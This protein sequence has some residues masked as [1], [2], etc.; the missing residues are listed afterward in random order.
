MQLSAARSSQ[1]NSHF[2][3]VRFG[4]TLA[5][6]SMG[7]SWSPIYLETLWPRKSAKAVLWDRKGRENFIMAKVGLFVQLL[8]VRPETT[9]IYQISGSANF[10][11]ANSSIH[12]NSSL[13]TSQH[14]FCMCDNLFHSFHN[15]HKLFT[16]HNKLFLLL[17]RK[18]ANWMIDWA[19]L[20]VVLTALLAVTANFII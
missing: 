4:S 8:F 19:D 3:S 15:C 17:C 1:V 7:E 18:T 16:I 6:V 9:R 14:K 12:V 2:H 10:L 5:W 13:P 11:I 20:K